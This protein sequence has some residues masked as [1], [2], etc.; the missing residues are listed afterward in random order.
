MKDLQ[1]RSLTAALAVVLLFVVVALPQKTDLA[2][3]IAK[4]KESIGTTAALGAVK[5]QLIVSNAQFTFKGAANVISGKALVLSTP[6]KSLWGMNFASPDYPQDRFG[7]DGKSVKV[8]RAT[9]NARSLIGDF[10]QNNREIIRE[11]LLGGTLSAAW[12]LLQDGVRGATLR[13][14]GTKAIDDRQT[15]VLA[16]VPKGGS[17]LAIRL[18][19]GTGSFQHFRT[20]YTLVQNA[21]T[22]PTV[23]TSAGQSGLIYR[24][25]EEFSNFSKMG[26]LM[27]P[28]TYTITYSRTGTA[29]TA[30]KLTTNRDAVWTFAVTDVGFNREID[31]N[32]FDIDAR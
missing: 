23:D 2:E 7:Y 6:D 3:L 14:E 9:T 20:E 8:G 11:G 10:L 13:Y 26:Q 27:L 16:Y 24:L 31:A 12:P 4:H 18:Y 32:S 21:A 22:G 29:S 30:T 19:F 17:D 15:H 25:T 5:N 28:R 1:F